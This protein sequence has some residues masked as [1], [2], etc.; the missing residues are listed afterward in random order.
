M[1]SK[2]HQKQIFTF[3]YLQSTIVVCKLVT[4]S[5]DAWEDGM[6][7]ELGITQAE[8]LGGYTVQVYNAERTICD[9]I[10]SRR[11]VEIQNLQVALREYVR[12]SN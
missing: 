11:N 5:E 12:Q 2:L 10:R 3:T 1:L 6:H 4:E 9:I 8:L 7:N